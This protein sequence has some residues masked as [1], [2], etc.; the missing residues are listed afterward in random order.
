[1]GGRG[2][3]EFKKKKLHVEVGASST[4]EFAQPMEATG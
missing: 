1:M 3:G 4:M 2:R